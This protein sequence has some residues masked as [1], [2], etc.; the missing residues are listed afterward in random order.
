MPERNP[1]Y[2]Q[3]EQKALPKTGE[4]EFSGRSRSANASGFDDSGSLVRR[5]RAMRAQEEMKD[6]L[7]KHIVDSPIISVVRRLALVAVTTGILG[8][9]GERAA[10]AQ[11]ADSQKPATAT[12]IEQQETARQRDFL[13]EAAPQGTQYE[14]QKQKEKFLLLIDN[15]PAVMSMLKK[16]GIVLKGDTLETNN[17]F[18]HFNEEKNGVTTERVMVYVTDEETLGLKTYNSDG[19]VDTVLIREGNVVSAV[20]T[21]K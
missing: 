16:Q 6:R 5:E 17:F 2:N 20:T 10:L 12:A 18:V 19:T 14:N 9:V 11:Q 13:Q 7:R 4:P 15:P 1:S 8:A 21:R 3:P